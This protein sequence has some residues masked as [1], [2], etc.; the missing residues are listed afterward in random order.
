MNAFKQ[1]VQTRSNAEKTT[2][3]NVEMFMFC[4]AALQQYI[5]KSTLKI[6]VN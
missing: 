6:N 5:M 1:L 2:K 3:L 4:E